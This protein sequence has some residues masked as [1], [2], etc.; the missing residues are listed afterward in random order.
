M[1]EPGWSTA[2]SNPNPNPA[3]LTL[4]LTLTPDPNQVDCQ[5][6]CD[7]VRGRLH[8]LHRRARLQANAATNL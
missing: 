1:C 5:L 8:W 3:T 2:D 7:G 4:T 6:R